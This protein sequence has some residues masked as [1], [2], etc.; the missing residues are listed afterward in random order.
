MNCGT[1]LP[2]QLVTFQKDQKEPLVDIYLETNN[3][4]QKY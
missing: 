2:K 1:E 4:M 3:S